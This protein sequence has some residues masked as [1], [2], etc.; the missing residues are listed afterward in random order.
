MATRAER[1]GDPL[2]DR[3]GAS[4][5]ALRVVDVDKTY[6][7]RAGAVAALRGAT[8]AAGHG[9]FVAMVGPSGCGKSTMLKILAGLEEKDAGIVELAGRPPGTGRR[10]CGIMLQAPVLLS[11]RTVLANVLLPVEIFGLDGGEGRRR[12]LELLSLV[13]LA[14]F[15]DKY[16]WE[17]SGGMQQ[18]VSLARLLVFDPEVLLMDEPFGALDEFTRERMN[19][20][21]ASLHERLGKLVVFVTH[22]ILEAVILSDKVVV[23]KPRPGEVI[24]VVDI[25][26]PRPR[27]R[28]VLDDPR[29]TEIVNH[30]RHLLV[31]HSEEVER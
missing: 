15:H 12:A 5:Q 25:D 28:E 1:A 19:F 6:D 14:D 21:L 9:E 18:R 10:D 24:E 20:E 11:W 27:R 23:M 31:A 17:L 7:T 22:N 4:G 8:F 2:G 16:P 13:G 30:I 3:L 26:L 29:T